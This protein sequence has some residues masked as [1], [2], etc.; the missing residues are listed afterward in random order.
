MNAMTKDT[1]D[2]TQ[3]TDEEL[4]TELMWRGWVV[5][6]ERKVL[7]ETLGSKAFKD[8]TAEQF[9]SHMMIQ[10][11]CRM[12]RGGLTYTMLG[13]L[14][15]AYPALVAYERV[16]LA[17]YGYRSDGGPNDPVG[18]LRVIKTKLVAALKGSPFTVVSHWGTGWQLVLDRDWQGSAET[19][20]DNVVDFHDSLKDYKGLKLTSNG[21]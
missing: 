20:M 17:A 3:V 4:I 12:P 7:E 2:F 18:C 9:A 11:G 14:L 5:H 16:V 10:Y 21:N 8:M 19:A 1:P 15:R 13:V 6:S